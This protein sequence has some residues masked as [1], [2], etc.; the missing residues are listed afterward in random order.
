MVTA[1]SSST[2]T[3]SAT[4]TAS[5]SATTGSQ[6]DRFLKLLVA[7]LNNQDPMNPMDNAEMTTQMAQI[8]TVTGVEQLN[9]TVKS[10]MAQLTATQLM[11][12]STLVGH[13]VL[14]P[15]NTLAM[16]DGTASAAFDLDV[17]ADNVKVSV[18][19][20]AGKTLETIDLGAIK[21]GRTNFSWDGSKYP[22]VVSPTYTVTAKAGTSTLTA[23]TYVRDNVSA[24]RTESDG[25]LT[26]QLRGL[27]DVPY[28][29]VSS[30]S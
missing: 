1:V 4:T 8:S 9:A 23:T 6:Q 17:D 12:G 2:D 10:L 27:G 26:L 21:A 28:T 25:T 3:G 16:K 11:Q 20:A 19:D 18:Q 24:V 29:Q 14:V 30:V 5:A 13:D 22:G 15:G 7:Q